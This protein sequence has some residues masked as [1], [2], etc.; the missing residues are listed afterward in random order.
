MIPTI[1]YSLSLTFYTLCGRP[2]STFKHL[3]PTLIWKCMIFWTYLIF[4]RYWTIVYTRPY[5]PHTLISLFVL[6]W[7]DTGPSHWPVHL[8]KRLILGTF[9]GLRRVEA[10][11][12]LLP[13]APLALSAAAQQEMPRLQAHQWALSTGTHRP[14]SGPDKRNGI[15]TPHAV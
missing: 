14:C 3:K 6:P 1:I 11:D 12:R 8:L 10:A 13:R 7:K 15:R 4:S 9:P 2:V 5:T